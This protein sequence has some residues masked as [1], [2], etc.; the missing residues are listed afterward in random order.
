MP[1][2]VTS[3]NLLMFTMQYKGSYKNTLQITNSSVSTLKDIM[4]SGINCFGKIAH[5]ET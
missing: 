3:S 2:N 1:N 4:Q 5:Y